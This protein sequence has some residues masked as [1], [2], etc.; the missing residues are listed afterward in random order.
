MLVES[1]VIML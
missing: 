1:A